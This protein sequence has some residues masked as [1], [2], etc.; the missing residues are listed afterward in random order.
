[1]SSTAPRPSAR[2]SHSA[3]L[4]RNPAFPRVAPFA[5]FIGLL[6]FQS[7]IPLGVHAQGWMT[8]LRALVVAAVM[9][10][11]WDGYVELRGERSRV[12]GQSGSAVRLSPFTFHLS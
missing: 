2:R 9:W 7:V 6:A 11:Y 1:M 3:S 10:N 8:V 4:I 12:K 5:A